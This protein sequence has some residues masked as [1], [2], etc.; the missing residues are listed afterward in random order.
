[1]DN[2]YEL[3]EI[4]SAKLFMKKICYGKWVEKQKKQTELCRNYCGKMFR[5]TK[6][7]DNLISE[8]EN[9]PI[10][11]APSRQLELIPQGLE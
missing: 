5:N 6:E 10:V 4:T 11:I 7:A 9:E 1:M 2:E 3:Q 8:A